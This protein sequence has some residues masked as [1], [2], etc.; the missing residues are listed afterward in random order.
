MLCSIQMPNWLINFWTIYGEIITPILVTLLTSILT[1]VALK[2]RS[3]AKV[4]SAKADLQIQALKEV[5]GKEDTKPEI[6]KQ[7]EEISNLRQVMFYMADMFN[8]AFQ[9][10]ALDPEI[11]ANISS[12]LNKCKYGSEDDLIKEL[13]ESNA[14]L[15]EQVAEL[16]AKATTDVTEIV[17]EEIR[18]RTRR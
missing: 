9:N 17:T 15:S 18:K 4:N 2:I 1:Y 14:R 5:A 8:V 16:T 7:S 13:E 3:D 12:L 11:K 6:A 10:T